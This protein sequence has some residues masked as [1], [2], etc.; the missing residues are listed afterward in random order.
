VS[1]FSDRDFVAGSLTRL[2]S[3]RVDEF[4]RLTGVRHKHVWQP[5]VNEAKCHAAWAAIRAGHVH[6]LSPSLSLSFSGP[7]PVAAQAPEPVHVVGQLNC[8][9]G[10]YAYFDEGD[11][12]HHEQGNVLALVEGHGVTTVGSR[13]FRCSKASIAVFIDEAPLPLWRR[14]KWYGWLLLLVMLSNLASGTYET[15]RTH[16]ANAGVLLGV[17]GAL[18]FALWLL[19]PAKPS[20]SPLPQVVRRN[21][22]DVPVYPSIAAALAEHPLTAPP[23]PTPESDPDFWTRKGHS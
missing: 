22:P 10:Y 3:F 23:P 7:E 11:N 1:L 16:W 13:G 17:A 2:R 6:R 14:V 21:Y 8:T 9:C 4:G 15:T 12:P 20:T 5:G 18:G 19:E